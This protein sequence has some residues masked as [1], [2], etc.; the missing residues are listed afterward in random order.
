MLSG[1]PV[2]CSCSV[3]E[4][5]SS[6]WTDHSV[7]FSSPVDGHLGHFQFGALRIKLL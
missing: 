2:V 6:A 4:R 7:F 5:S 3:A 1:V